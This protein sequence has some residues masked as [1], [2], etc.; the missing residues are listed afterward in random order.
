[1]KIPFWHSLTVFVGFFAVVFV[2][3][4]APERHVNIVDLFDAFNGVRILVAEMARLG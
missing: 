1:M 2:I 3:L 4:A